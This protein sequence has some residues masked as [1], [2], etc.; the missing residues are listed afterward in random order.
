MAVEQVR[1]ESRQGLDHRDAF[2]ELDHVQYVPGD[3]LRALS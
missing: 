3:V 2:K 1:I